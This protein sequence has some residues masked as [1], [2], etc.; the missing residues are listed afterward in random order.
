[1]FF[2]LKQDILNH[3]VTNGMSGSSW[4]FKCF[5]SLSV[6]ILDNESEAVI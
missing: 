4:H 2:G 3:F 6:K 1:M 5:I